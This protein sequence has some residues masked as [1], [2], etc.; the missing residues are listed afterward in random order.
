MAMHKDRAERLQ[1]LYG[2]SKVSDSKEMNLGRG[3]SRGI[4]NG[5]SKEYFFL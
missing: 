3:G 5:K 4:L 1:E 2:H